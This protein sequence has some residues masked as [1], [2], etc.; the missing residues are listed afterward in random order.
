MPWL[1]ALGGFLGGAGG[2]ALASFSQKL[3]PIL[4]GGMPVVSPWTNGI[5][6]YETATLGAILATL[7]T[8]LSS[9]RLPDWR[10]KLHDPEISRG[11]ILVG[12]TNP[13]EGSRQEIEAR[14]REAG[15]KEV[16]QF[17]PAARP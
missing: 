6:T 8:L 16:R 1:A 12:V 14:L 10:A 5:I 11:N 7:V 15:A 9:A 4:T 13:P 17:P 3:Y 2:Y